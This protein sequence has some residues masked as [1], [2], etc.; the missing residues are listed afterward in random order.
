MNGL[1]SEKPEKPAENKNILTWI[2]FK[3]K[4]KEKEDKREKKEKKSKR[5]PSETEKEK[6]KEKEKEST[7]RSSATER[8]GVEETKKQ[9]NSRNRAAT[10]QET[11]SPKGSA[12]T[13]AEYR[14]R[15]EKE[16]EKKKK[17]DTSNTSNQETR[18]QIHTNAASNTSKDSTCTCASTVILATNSQLSQVTPETLNQNSTSVPGFVATGGTSDELTSSAS[19]TLSSGSR[20]YAQTSSQ[21]QKLCLSDSSGSTITNELPQLQSHHNLH[22]H[23]LHH[24]HQSTP[25]LQQQQDGLQS[26]PSSPQLQSFQQIQQPQLSLDAKQNLK[27]QLSSSSSSSI[28]PLSGVSSD[29]SSKG[30]SLSSTQLLVQQAPPP[31]SASSTQQQPESSAAET[32]NSRSLVGLF[33]S[34][35][36]SS[37]S[38]LS[39][40]KICKSPTEGGYDLN[41]LQIIKII[42]KGTFGRVYLTQA[43]RGD[44]LFAL[45]MLD[46]LA[47]IRLKQVDHVKYEKQILSQLN[48][49]FIVRMYNSFQDAGNLYLLLD[50][51]G[52]GEMFYWLRNLG[53]FSVEVC[54]FYASEVVLALEYIHSLNVAYR[55]LKPENLL[56]DRTG[57]IKLVDFGFAKK[58]DAGS[59][60]FT[61]CGTPE[62]LAPEIIQKKGHGRAVDW[63]ALGILI[64]EMLAGFSPFFDDNQYV[65][66]EKI[67]SGRIHFPSFFDAVTKD[68]IKRFLQPESARLGNLKGGAADVKSHKWFS[69]LQWDDVLGMRIPPPIV[70]ANNL[71]SLDDTSLFEE[72]SDDEEVFS[73]KVVLNQERFQNLFKDF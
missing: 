67:L 15:E 10:T 23:L 37:S 58:V 18:N 57:H 55:D 22:Q 9:E 60:T 32:G 43:K 52:G 17:E 44:K 64:Y 16:K 5:K 65:I 45:K 48:F 31:T 46:K 66:Y 62:Y 6:E 73:S 40:S 11:K 33:K 30:P 71:A 14:E 13:K 49:P 28:S 24:L 7:R 34:L 56:L 1:K 50:F 72:Y 59:K 26:L 27:P 2:N 8:P 54:R 35:L 63:W 29:S 53:R 70:P 38:A 21:F 20:E 3:K 41:S 51:A 12:L 68:L 42:G 69:S 19:N 36:S 25:Q 4:D 47:V 61:L 39:G